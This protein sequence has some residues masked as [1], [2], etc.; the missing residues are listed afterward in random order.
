MTRKSAGAGN[1]PVIPRKGR[2][3]HKKK[4]ETRWG[5]AM[6]GVPDSPREL[7]IV[8]KEGRGEKKSTGDGLP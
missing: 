4:K 2:K 3:D 1:G 8:R 5:E 7:W 6:G